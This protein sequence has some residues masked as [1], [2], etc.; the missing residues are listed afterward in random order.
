MDGRVKSRG[1]RSLAKRHRGSRLSVPLPA[2]RPAVTAI[3]ILSEA[4]LLATAARLG[5]MPPM[6][7]PAG[8][9]GPRVGP[10]RTP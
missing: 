6:E 8:C 1:R 5:S 9:D 3:W 10:D 7:E 2:A 4:L